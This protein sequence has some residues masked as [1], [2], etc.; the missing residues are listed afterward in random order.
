VPP[1]AMIIEAILRE[2]YGGKFGAPLSGEYVLPEN[3]KKFFHS[4]KKKKT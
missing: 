2:I 1:K 3:L 4:M